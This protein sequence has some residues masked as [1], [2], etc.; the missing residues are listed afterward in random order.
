VAPNVLVLAIGWSILEGLG[1]ALVMPALAALIA[2][3]YE[4]RQRAV[5][6]SVIGAVAGAGIAVGPIVGGWARRRSP[7]GRVRRRGGHRARVL[8]SVR[9]LRD[10]SSDAARP[11]LDLVGVV[12]LALALGL[13]VSGCCRPARGAGSS[14]RTRRSSP[15]A[16]L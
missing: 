5:A 4:G 13:V 9:L 15:S 12:A 7:G 14:R 10:A 6:Y 8:A 16:S 3:N 1:A 11:R 2:G